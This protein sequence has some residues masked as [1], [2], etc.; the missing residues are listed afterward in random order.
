MTSAALAE[1]SPPHVHLRAAIDPARAQRRRRG[2]LV[3]AAMVSASHFVSA[4][5]FALL[6]ASGAIE[7]AVP[8]VYA[9]VAFSACGIFFVVLG[10]GWTDALRDHY[11]VMPHMAVHALITLAFIVW[12]PQIGVLLIMALFV[13][14]AF[15]ALRM[16]LRRVLVGSLVM[17]LAIGAVI[18]YL[19]PRLALP[20]ATWQQRAVCGLWFA[21]ILVCSTLIGLYGSRLRGLLRE[22]NAQLATTLKQLDRLAHHDELTGTLNR[23]SIMQ[24]I[25]EERQRMERSGQPF[26][27]ALFDIDHFKRVN[28]GFGHVVGDEVLRRFV[29]RVA[30]A[31]RHT[32]RLGRYGG[33]EFLMLLTATADDAAAL[34]AAERVRLGVAQH[35]WAAVAPGLEITVSAGIGVCRGGESIEQLLTRADSALY[36]AKR[37]GRN[38]V[39]AA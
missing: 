33:E 1:P 13:I 34:V 21:L 29:A 10:S 16:N 9:A 27:I 12:V 11:I 20:V 17:A 35:D 24:L 2:R 32:D 7:G 4:V 36:V 37:D 38:C 8:I 5:L 15:G 19:G 28:D 22:R 39:R 26:G 14:F 18:A 6:W 31:M 30:A 3:T 25:E 23:R